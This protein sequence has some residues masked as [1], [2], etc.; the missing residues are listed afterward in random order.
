[1]LTFIDLFAGAGGFSEGFLQA[2][3]KGTCYDFLLAGDINPTC[4]VTHRIRYNEQLKLPTLFLTK[5]ITDPD[6][7]ETL[8]AMLEKEY[9]E[10]RIDVLVG[11]PPCQ[12]FSLAGERRKND[13]KDDLF[14]Y[15]LKVIAVLKPKYFV[16][17]NVSGILTK[18]NG[19]I[20]ERIL[21]D[22][23]N[24]VDFGHLADLCDYI[25]ASRPLL[26]LPASSST[27]LQYA[28]D[29]LR[30]AISQNEAENKRRVDYLSILRKIDNGDYS[31]Q[32][33]TL[34]LRS[35]VAEKNNLENALYGAFV[36]RIADKFVDAFRNNKEIP[37]D[38]RNVIRQ[39]LNLIKRRQRLELI[40]QKIKLTINESHLNRS[41]YKERFDRTTDYLQLSE[42]VRTFDDAIASLSARVN[43]PAIIIVLNDTQRAV[44]ILCEDTMATV[45]RIAALFREADGKDF[46]QE[47]D[48]MIKRVQ[49]YQ[50]DAPI[51][52][53]ASD[54][55][56]PQNR[57][58]IVFIG[59]RN[60][61]P[62]INT[63]PPTV[64]EA[65][66]VGVAEAIGDLGYIEIGGKEDKYDSAFNKKFARSK[67]GMIKRT[68]FGK[69]KP[70]GVGRY[71][72]KKTYS[73][74]SR[75]GRLNPERFPA[76]KPIYTT[77]NSVD[78]MNQNTC[79]VVEL[80]NHEVS[81]H[82]NVVRARYALIRKYGGYAA[83]KEIEPNNPLLTGT[84]KRN[85]SCLFAN[86]PSTTIVTIGDDFTHYAADRS[87]TVR[88]MARLQSFDDSFV[89]Q[90]KRTTGGD[91]RKLETP[92]Y[93]QVGNAVPPLM[94]HAIALE[95]L[96]NIK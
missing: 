11:G 95:I 22:I 57:Q 2:E 36:D 53:N 38:E 23:H 65:E 89:F 52:L 6:Y 31:E 83:A 7:V 37:E 13:K 75:Q 54:Y 42:I 49:L 32:E 90:G 44:K 10:K 56:V 72:E 51:Q 58:R 96:K 46:A 94:A 39:T 93:T 92:Q 30:I 33:K 55:G 50:I 27:E 43:D 70:D 29:K 77:A 91:R 80:A 8:C 78:E 14:S 9:G 59:C 35:I 5:D 67:E 26:A 66:K 64:T 79:E 71:S 17:E 68:I 15:Y 19:K 20:K 62:V 69:L 34:L 24:I 21:L 4:E 47:L 81:N 84:N 82:N 3:Y 60:D 88:E 74:W 85:Y 73:E 1:M 25:D 41:I 16:M 87:L 12:S 61:Q 86:K 18:D 76:I 48:G 45:H 28:I 63:I 40:V